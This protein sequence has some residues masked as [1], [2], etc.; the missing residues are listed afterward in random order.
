M[1]K[2]LDHIIDQHFS[3]LSELLE[4]DIVIVLDKQ[5]DDDEG[6]LFDEC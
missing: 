6:I 5:D 1:P 2:E 4:N 3:R